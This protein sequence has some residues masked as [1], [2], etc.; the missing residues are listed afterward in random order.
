MMHM[1]ISFKILNQKENKSVF[2]QFKTHFLN[3][4]KRSACTT[5]PLIDMFHEMREAIDMPE[6]SIIINSHAKNRSFLQELL[7][8]GVMFKTIIFATTSNQTTR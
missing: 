1:M 7:G 3:K 8:P 5:I 4:W 6:I 2:F